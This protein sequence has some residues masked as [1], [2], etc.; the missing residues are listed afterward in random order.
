MA[1]LDPRREL[2]RIGRLAWRQGCMA[3]SDGNLSCRLD[4]ERLL[5]TP[6]GCCK[7]E[8]KPQDLLEVDLEGKVLA[9]QGRPSSELGLHLEAYQAQPQ[10]GAVVH[11]HPPLATALT[12]AGVPLSCQA[13][14][15]LLIYLDEVPTVPYATPGTPELA[16]AAAPYLARHRAVLL[17]QHGS[18]TLGP[19]LASAWLLTE[20]LEHAAQMLLAAHS[21]GGARPLPLAEQAR[22]RSLGHGGG[23]LP[24]LDQ[25]VEITVLPR[26]QE[27]AVEKIHADQR[28]E[29][30]LIADNRPLCRLGVLTLRAGSGW[31]GGHLHWGKGEGF[32]IYQGRARAQL[33]CGIS[34]ERLDLT[35]EPGARLWIPAGVA[36]RFEALED[37]TFVEFTDSPYQAADDLPY[38]F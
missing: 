4:Q 36:H 13:L 16:R 21:L 15:E 30:H 28:G 22:L 9:G 35:L 20:K 12:L 34:G 31:R 19:D 25:R 26:T 2:L 7:G 32:Y 6:S 11:A 1:K 3:A 8:L 33:A 14:P 24:P 5:V 29:A 37:L 18:L 27:F 23:Q 10:T 17:A 38:Q